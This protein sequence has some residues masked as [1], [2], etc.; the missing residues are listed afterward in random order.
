MRKL[1]LLGTIVGGIILVTGCSA[2]DVVKDGM[3]TTTEAGIIDGVSDIT[4]EMDELNQPGEESENQQ[5]DDVDIKIDAGQYMGQIDSNSIEVRIVGIQP[6]EEAFK[7]FRLSDEVKE[8]FDGY[9]LNEND[10]IILKYKIDNNGVGVI[11]EIQRNNQSTQN[12]VNGQFFVKGKNGFVSLGEWD[13]KI[14]LEK[15]FGN[16]LSERIEQ[17]DDGA[18]T[19]TGSYVKN[20]EFEGVKVNL[21]SP[22]N[23][24]E[25]FWIQSIIITSKDYEFLDGI[26]IGDSLEYVKDNL[27]EDLVEAN[28]VDQTSIYLYNVGSDTIELIFVDNILNKVEAYGKTL[29]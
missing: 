26:M 23:N 4:N 18:D 8:N 14:D 28:N 29:C 6:E 12:E 20:I 5:I 1:L 25:T 21:F 27:P 11:Y 24:G 3:G 15:V 13:N 7:A 16:K 22:K 19:F 9:S 10:F 2:G 17:F